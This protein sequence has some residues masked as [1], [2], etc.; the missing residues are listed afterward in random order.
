MCSSD[1]NVKFLP[2]RAR[3][4]PVTALEQW[5]DA[6]RIT[7]GPLFRRIDQWGH[8]G[9][10]R[11]LAKTAPAIVRRIVVTAEMA[12]GASPAAAARTASRYAMT[13]LRSGFIKSA[14]AAGASEERVATHLGYTSAQVLRDHKRRHIALR[15]HPARAVLQKKRA[16]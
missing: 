7:C 12:A 9:S 13:S 3:L 15:D 4:C 6:A 10:A 1:L 14:F 16:T 5:V 11:L 2:R 8:I